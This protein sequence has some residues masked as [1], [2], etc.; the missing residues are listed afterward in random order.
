MKN[1]FI[2]LAI[3]FTMICCSWGMNYEEAR[4]RAWFL[5]DKMAYE[6]DLTEEQ[7]NRVYEINLDYLLNI[8]TPKDLYSS[9]WTYRNEDMQCVLFDWQ[10]SLYQL[11]NYFYRP[12]VWLKNNWYL[13]LYDN[14][15]S[16]YY[17]F[18]RPVVVNVYRGRLGVVRGP[19]SPYAGFV[20]H[21]GKGLRENFYPRL[22]GNRRGV[23]PSLIRSNINNRYEK[24]F[25]H[26]SFR[27]EQPQRYRP[28][29]GRMQ[30]EG[31]NNH[32]V[33][34]FRGQSFGENR[35]KDKEN[36]GTPS[37]GRSNSSS[38]GTFSQKDRSQP[39][40]SSVK[41]AP[42]RDKGRSSDNPAPSSRFGGSKAKH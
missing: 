30:V 4:Q 34:D 25:P 41:S 23:N 20:I 18:N 7:Y 26:E 31:R 1:G 14:Y 22:V 12:I 24:K 40:Q 29:T 17:Y 13:S 3:F 6:L 9:Y 42:Q 33:G 28:L 15:R 16:D 32:R 5:T 8:Q 38:P 27:M 19:K 37:F 2:F 36:K 10:F 39:S 11:R 35:G 21:R